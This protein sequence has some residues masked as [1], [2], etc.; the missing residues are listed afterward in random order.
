[1][2]LKSA[3]RSVR[4]PD[5]FVGRRESVIQGHRTLSEGR[6]SRTGPQK[7]Y[8]ADRTAYERAQ[9]P[10]R[11]RSVPPCIVFNGWDVRERSHLNIK[12]LRADALALNG[13]TRLNLARI[14]SIATFTS[15]RFLEL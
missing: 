15:R 7:Q 12:D 8:G 1:V 3:G 4:P 11:H 9:K 6:Y 2:I 13:E 14:R 5:Q 10:V